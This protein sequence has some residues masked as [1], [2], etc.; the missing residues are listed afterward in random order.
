MHSPTSTGPIKVLE[1]IQW[2]SPPMSRYSIAPFCRWML[3]MGSERA[4]SQAVWGC[5]ATVGTN[6]GLYLQYSD[7]HP[8]R[9]EWAEKRVE[10]HLLGHFPIDLYTLISP[11]PIIMKLGSMDP[12]LVCSGPMSTFSY[13]S[14]P[15]SR[16]RYEVRLLTERYVSM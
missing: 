13:D 10:W 8:E 6:T 15:I 9:R 5:E 14:H 4:E 12:A 3:N 2:R 1:V 16:G 11:Q 7:W